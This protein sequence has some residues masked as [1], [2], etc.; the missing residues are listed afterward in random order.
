MTFQF[1]PLQ[2]GIYATGKAHK[3][4]IPSLGNVPI[5]CVRGR[6]EPGHTSVCL[7]VCR[8]VGRSACVSL[9][10]SVSVS[11]FLSLPMSLSLS[12]SLALSFSLPLSVK[13]SHV[14]QKSK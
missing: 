11:L 9:C 2:N 6:L 4:T 3:R 10:L 7:S 12:L 8:S 1:R 14:L 5:V 13:L